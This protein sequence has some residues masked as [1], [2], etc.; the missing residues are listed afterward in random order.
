MPAVL[1]E[2]GSII[3]R[4][5]ELRVGSP[6][7]QTRIS[8]AVTDAV[9]AFCAARRPRAPSTAASGPANLSRQTAAPTRRRGAGADGQAALAQSGKVGS[10]FSAPGLAANV[11]QCPP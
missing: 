9:E 6:E 10:R 8:T 3:N 7:H 5:E 1:L 2:A 11:V 4:D